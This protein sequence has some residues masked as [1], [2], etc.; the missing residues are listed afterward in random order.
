MPF[1][2]TGKERD[3]ES[4]LDYFGAR[5]YASSMGR[6]MSPDWASKPEAVP[7]SSLDN[8]QSL[9]LYGYVGN[10]PLSRADADGHCCSW[11]EVKQFAAG[12]VNAWGS[13]NLAGAGRIDQTTAAGIAGARLGDGIAA[14]QGIYE[15]VQGAAAVLGGGA[16]ALVTSPA[17]GTGVGVVVP[18]AGAVVAVAGAAEAVHGVATA[19]TA[20]TALMKSAQP[21][22][23]P[24][25]GQPGS[26]SQTTQPDGSPKQVRQYGSDGHPQT[27]VDH[28]HDHGQGDPHAHDWSRP[29]NGGPPTHENRGDG[30]P[31]RPNDPKPQ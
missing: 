29:A 16:E 4:G 11:D 21:K 31:V 6:W 1:K 17:A 30:R 19:G 3:T 9:N 5:Y 22:S 23:N 7:Y 13:D 26:T 8:P 18:A 24:M 20:V 14:A 2:F 15:T 27:D 10:N 25:T 12:A 28:G